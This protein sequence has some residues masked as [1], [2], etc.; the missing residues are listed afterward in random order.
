MKKLFRSIPALVRKDEIDSTKIEMEILKNTLYDSWK[1]RGPLT[2]E[3]RMTVLKDLVEQV[4]KESEI[5]LEEDKTKV[6]SSENILDIVKGIQL[7]GL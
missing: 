3:Q 2:K 4:K 5:E 6:V 7:F 1:S